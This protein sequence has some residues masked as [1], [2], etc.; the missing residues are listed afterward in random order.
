[1]THQALGA[2]LL[3]LGLPPA[4]LGF[5]G[6]ALRLLTL[7]LRL[8][9]AAVGRC[10]PARC[11]VS[12][13]LGQPGAPLEPGALVRCLLAQRQCLLGAAAPALALGLER[14]DRRQV[15]GDKV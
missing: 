6:A 9:A 12:G 3:G 4:V 14:A 11:L 13:V 5:A 8:G 7:E 2:L 1:V 10:R 15:G